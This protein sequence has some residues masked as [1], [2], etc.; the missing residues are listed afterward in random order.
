MRDCRII[1]VNVGQR[2][3]LNVLIDVIVA[4]CTTSG[5]VVVIVIGNFAAIDI[6]VIICHTTIGGILI[7][8]SQCTTLYIIVIIRY[9]S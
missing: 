4:T 8:I 9:G 2:S 1:L 7:D 6:V 5:I 3:A